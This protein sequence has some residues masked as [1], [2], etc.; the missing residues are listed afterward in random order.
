MARKLFVN[1]PLG[2]SNNGA[3]QLLSVSRAVGPAKSMQL[4]SLPLHLMSMFSVIVVG[5]IRPRYR[6]VFSA[7]SPSLLTGLAIPQFCITTEKKGGNF[8]TFFKII[9]RIT[10]FKTW[11]NITMV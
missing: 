3:K 4:M 11:L 8:K 9:I 2:Q 10:Y 5:A 1:W 6:P 7:S